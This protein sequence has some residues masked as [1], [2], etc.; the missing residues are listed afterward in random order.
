LESIFQISV[1]LKVTKRTDI[2]LP[3]QK[4]TLTI[5]NLHDRK[6]MGFL[7]KPG[8]AFKGFVK[9]PI[10]RIGKDLDKMAQPAQV[11]FLLR[12]CFHVGCNFHLFHRRARKGRMLL[13]CLERLG[14]CSMAGSPVLF[15]ELQLVP[16]MD[17]IKA[18]T[19]TRCQKFKK[20]FPDFFLFK[21][22]KSGIVG[23]AMY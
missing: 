14:V 11:L 23:S 17:A 21:S 16:L 22:E 10:G 1:C 7:N 18:C 2:N 19:T 20:R 9:D 8:K 6:T 3:A 12:P 4:K 13:S 15:E 5:N